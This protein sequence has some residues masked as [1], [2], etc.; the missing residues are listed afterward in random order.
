ML[1]VQGIN[2]SGIPDKMWQPPFVV[3]ET[4]LVN[5]YYIRGCIFDE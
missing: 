5:C 3:F 2:Q 4:T 1:A